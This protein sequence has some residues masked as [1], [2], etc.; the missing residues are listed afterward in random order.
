VPPA[1]A[2]VTLE[3]E[4]PDQPPIEFGAPAPVPVDR[5]PILS[6]AAEPAPVVEFDPAVDAVERALA[7]AREGQHAEAIEAAGP[8]LKSAEGAGADQPDSAGGAVGARGLPRL[9]PRRRGGYRA[10]Y[11]GM[12]AAPDG[13]TEGCPGRSTARAGPAARELLAAAERISPASAER[14][15]LLRMAVLWLEWRIVA[16]PATKEV[17]EL[18][19]KA[20]ETLWEGYA[21]AGRGLLLRRQFAHARR[22]VR[23]ALDSEDLPATRRGPLLAL[24]A[25]GV[26]RQIGRLVATARG[27]ETPESA[28]LHAPDLA[29]EILDAA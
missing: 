5:P 20:R 25:Q 7:R 1:P 23:E 9:R 14:V 12:R 10:R 2:A 19:D 11:A 29:R 15:A 27:R 3:Q 17:S 13:G 6:L 18:L 4:L 16:A 26:V 28:A 8:H 22:L 21:L 24:A